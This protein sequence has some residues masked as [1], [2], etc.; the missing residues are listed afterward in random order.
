LAAQANLPAVPASRQALPG[1]APTFQV[2]KTWKRFA[3]AG[4]QPAAKT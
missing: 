2:S 3:G 4:Q 1:A